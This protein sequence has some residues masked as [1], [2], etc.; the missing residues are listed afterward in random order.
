MYFWLLTDEI[1]KNIPILL[2]TINNNNNDNIFIGIKY[3]DKYIIVHKTSFIG[4]S[5]KYIIVNAAR[6]NIAAMVG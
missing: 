3:N 1:S 4:F 2:T 6:E 5:M